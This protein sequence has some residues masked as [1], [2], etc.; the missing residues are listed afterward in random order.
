MLTIRPE[1]EK[2]KEV[3]KQVTSSVYEKHKF[4]SS[5]LYEETF[6]FCHFV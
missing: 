6:D 4:P 3:T 1:E 5:V 2:K